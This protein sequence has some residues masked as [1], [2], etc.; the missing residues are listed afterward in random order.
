MAATNTVIVAASSLVDL[1]RLVHSYTN[2]GYQIVEIWYKRRWV[3]W[4]Y[5]FYAKLE[6]RV[7]IE[8]RIGPISTRPLPKP[9]EKVKIEFRIGPIS[10]KES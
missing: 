4:L 1:M 7:K 10:Q 5:T 3:P 6:L 2:R 9:P 8:F